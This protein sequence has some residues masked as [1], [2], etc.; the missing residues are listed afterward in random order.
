MRPIYSRARY[1]S[2]LTG[3][4]TL[5]LTTFSYQENDD[6]EMHATESV[7]KIPEDG[8]EVKTDT[9]EGVDSL[10]DPVSKAEER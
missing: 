2:T 9:T 1:A 5:L 4:A 8:K 6:K 3:W 7:P 10:S